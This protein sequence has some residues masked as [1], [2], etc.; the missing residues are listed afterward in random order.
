[1]GHCQKYM[2]NYTEHWLTAICLRGCNFSVHPILI[3]V[4]SLLMTT[5]D[6]IQ[7]V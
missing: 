7:S 1:M 2:D 3:R 4:I 5:V 6:W